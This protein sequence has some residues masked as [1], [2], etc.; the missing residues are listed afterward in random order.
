M[1]SLITWKMLN[2]ILTMMK[3]FKRERLKTQMKISKELLNDMSYHVGTVGEDKIY[4]MLTAELTA[5]IHTN[6]AEERDIVYYCPAPSFLDWLLRRNKK[7]V[8]KLK[9]KDLLLNA[10]KPPD[11]ERIYI[12]EQ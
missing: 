2:L 11:T 6:M 1:T 12:I 10:P 4:D 5:Y 3:N 9:V 8:F 7:V